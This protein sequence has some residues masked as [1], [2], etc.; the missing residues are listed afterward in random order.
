[1]KK[2]K[3]IF[4]L[5]FAL[6]PLY[7][8]EAVLDRAGIVNVVR[9]TEI[10]PPY[11]EKIVL[12]PFRG[13][14]QDP[15]LQ[16][17]SE[18]ESAHTAEM[19]TL[20]PTAFY[21]QE[22]HI[23]QQNNQYLQ[24]C[25]PIDEETTNSNKEQRNLVLNTLMERGVFIQK[26]STYAENLSNIDND[27]ECYNYTEPLE[28]ESLEF[29]SFGEW[30]GIDDE[31]E[32]AMA[33]LLPND[34]TADIQLPPAVESK[35]KG[36]GRIIIK[37]PF[38]E[39]FLGTGFFIKDQN[40]NVKFI[41]SYHAVTG[42]LYLLHELRIDHWFS[43][44]SPLSIS[45]Q[46][47]D[48][49]FQITGV[50]DFSMELDMAVMEVKNY[51]GE[52]LKLAKNNKALSYILGYPDG[53]FEKIRVVDVFEEHTSASILL[54]DHN[55]RDCESLSGASGSPVLNNKG[56]VTGIVHSS[57]GCW[58]MIVTREDDFNKINITQPAHKNKETLI[59]AIAQ[60]E[61]LFHNQVLHQGNNPEVLL[62]SIIY[63]ENSMFIADTLNP[64]QSNKLIDIYEKLSQ[65]DNALT[66]SDKRFLKILVQN[67]LT[68]V[69]GSMKGRASQ[70][71]LSLG[72]TQ[73][74]EGIRLYYLLEFE[75]A[76][77]ILQKAIQK[78]FPQ[79]L[80]DLSEIYYDENNKAQACALLTFSKVPIR[81]LAQQYHEYECDPFLNSSDS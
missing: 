56:E 25:S 5:I 51:S 54:I 29:I 75:S 73:F 33:Q 22:C 30:L 2:T 38:Q 65:F 28:D 36:I 60:Q 47:D 16:E 57:M 46:T 63:Q 59:S 52:V 39:M 6:S 55:I 4:L 72:R 62:Q 64:P 44:N 15:A 53:E 43:E 81:G 41:T 14:Y 66:E 58:D 77:D 13:P 35:Q 7:A 10:S 19:I 42:I 24:I 68:K 49:Q 32:G 74:F 37:M 23:T 71:N 48:G 61:M 45:I 67:T 50:G 20:E 21:L 1:M 40:D 8:K 69:H 11:E 79:D 26:C 27:F 12:D 34:E 9:Q 76:R 31:I 78:R 17:V 3:I 80:L 70:T 18:E